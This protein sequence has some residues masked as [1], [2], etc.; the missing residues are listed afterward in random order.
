MCCCSV[1]LSSFLVCVRACVR[2]SDASEGRIGK[3][4]LVG[5][6]KGGWGGAAAEKLLTCESLPVLDTAFTLGR[7][8]L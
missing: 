7:S 3:G 4:Q 1:F 8:A 5:G 2:A 6:E